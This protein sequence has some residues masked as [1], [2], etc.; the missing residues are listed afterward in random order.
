MLDD[1]NNDLESLYESDISLTPPPVINGLTTLTFL[2]DL[3]HYFRSLPISLLPA[4]PGTPGTD[5]VKLLS[6]TVP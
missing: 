3:S 5:L 1:M 6:T 2:E 4:V